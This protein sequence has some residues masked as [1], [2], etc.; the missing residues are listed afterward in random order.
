MT[1]RIAGVFKEQFHKHIKKEKEKEKEKF[2]TE[3]VCVEVQ[4]LHK[5][6]QHLQASVLA[7]QRN[8]EKVQQSISASDSAAYA[9]SEVHTLILQFGLQ[10][11]RET[12]VQ[13]GM[14]S[15]FRILNGGRGVDL[16]VN[17]GG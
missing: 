15:T 13:R 16:H 1:G 9:H 10:F 3:K 11:S 8:I 2:V 4:Q 12:H 17:R 5:K 7:M 6:A 14:K